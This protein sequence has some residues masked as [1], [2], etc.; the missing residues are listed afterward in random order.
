LLSAL[1]DNG[2]FFR[3]RQ[4]AGDEVWTYV[5][6]GPTGQYANRFIDQKTVLPRLIFWIMAKW[7]ATGYL[8]WGYNWSAVPVAEIDTTHFLPA[9]GP[10]QSGD[11]CVVYPGP[12]GPHDS[13]RWEQQREGVQDYELLRLLGARDGGRARDICSRL[14][15]DIDRYDTSAAAFRAARRELLEALSG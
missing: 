5:C 2:E 12:H 10:V 7:G 3:R 14:V 11:A 13:I 9:Q 6:C 8:H 4:Q 15:Q 1:K